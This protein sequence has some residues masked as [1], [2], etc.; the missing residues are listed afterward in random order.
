MKITV[1]RDVM[2]CTLIEANILEEPTATI[3]G[4]DEYEEAGFSQMLV[5]IYQTT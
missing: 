3:I 1:F 2:L 4:V 5:T